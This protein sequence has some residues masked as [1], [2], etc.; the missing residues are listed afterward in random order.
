MER[1]C[2]NGGSVGAVGITSSGGKLVDGLLKL[3][4]GHGVEAGLERRSPWRIWHVRTWKNA[5]VRSLSFDASHAD[6]QSNRIYPSDAH[7]IP[8]FTVPIAG[9]Q[10]WNSEGLGRECSFFQVSSL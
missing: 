7:S 1:T 3:C 9:L 8:G 4:V 6:A 5:E 2:A 10:D